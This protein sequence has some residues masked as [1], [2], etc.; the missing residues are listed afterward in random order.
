[1][2]ALIVER[3]AKKEYLDHNLISRRTKKNTAIH[4]VFWQAQIAPGY[5]LLQMLTF[6]GILKGIDQWD[7][8]LFSRINQDWINPFFDALMPF[9]RTSN[10]WMPLYLFLFVF[11]LINFKG[12]GAWW[13]LFFLSTIA[14]TDLTGTQLFKHNFERLRPCKDPEMLVHLRLLINS[15]SGGYS[16]ISNHAANHFGMASF[17]FFTFRK[18]LPRWAWLGFAWAGLIAYSQV[19]IG[20]HY[21]SDVLSGALV[22]LLAGR[23]T[24]ALFNKRFG[25]TIFDNQSIAAS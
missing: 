5:L 20:V 14:I 24:S 12:K 3:T 13:F 8:Q 4:T 21:P 19:Y 23:L 18:V 2:Q 15:C 11:V 25:F 17:F 22:G 7:R 16:F 9:V 10:H 6:L 1:V